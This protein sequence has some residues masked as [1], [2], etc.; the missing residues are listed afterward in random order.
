MM[1]QLL[2]LLN[3]SSNN[4]RIV[5]VLAAG[6]E[7][8]AIYLDDLELKKPE[9]F[10]MFSTART[11]TTSTTLTMSRL[12]QENPRVVMIHHYPGG[13]NTGVF[14]R[15]FGD[16]WFFWILSAL[17]NLVGSSAEDA[18]EKVL[19]LLTSAKYG[20]KGVSLAAGGSRELTMAKTEDTGSL[21]LMRVLQGLQQDKVMAELKRMD[22]GNIVWQHTQEKLG[23][24][25]A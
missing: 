3:A 10:S 5:S 17:V 24:Y 8:S 9:H 2:P 16:R 7:S 25:I 15:A 6:N 14:K 21:F 19:F 18:G 1:M 22:A 13:V 23:Q 20:G 11:S 4:P 12:A